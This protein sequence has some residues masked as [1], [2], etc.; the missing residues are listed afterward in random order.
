MSCY[1]SYDINH[2]TLAGEQLGFEKFGPPY[3]FLRRARLI[4]DT[5]NNYRIALD[6]KFGET[7][8]FFAEMNDLKNKIG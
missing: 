6:M 8:L 4:K 5:E 7:N 3:D 2:L 1:I